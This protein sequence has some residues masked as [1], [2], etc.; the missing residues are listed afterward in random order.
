MN[1]GQMI[2]DIKLALECRL[3]VEFYGRN[4]GVVPSVREVLAKIE[5]MNEGRG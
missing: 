2:Y 3:P 5:E 4:G 1:K